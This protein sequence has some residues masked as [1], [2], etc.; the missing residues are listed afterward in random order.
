MQ[1][2][3][4]WKLKWSP[5]KVGTCHEQLI[6]YKCE[7][8]H[9]LVACFPGQPENECQMVIWGDQTLMLIFPPIFNDNNSYHDDYNETQKAENKG[10]VLCLA[11]Q[12]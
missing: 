3:K 1:S 5:L 2:R 8:F 9:Y 10:M 4:E 12:Q 6:H 7:Q 11:N